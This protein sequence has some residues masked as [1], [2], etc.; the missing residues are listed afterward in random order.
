MIIESLFQVMLDWFW[1]S[2]S[3]PFL[4]RRSCGYT[5]YTSSGARNGRIHQVESPNMGPK[6][7]AIDLPL[8]LETEPPVGLIYSAAK[9]SWR[10]QCGFQ[11]KEVNLLA[12]WANHG[13]PNSNWWWCVLLMKLGYSKIVLLGY[14]GIYTPCLDKPLTSLEKWWRK[15]GVF[16]T[17]IGIGHWMFEYPKRVSEFQWM[18]WKWPKPC[19][20]GFCKGLSI[21]PVL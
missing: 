4:S 17:Q 3:S 16:T 2:M 10:C 21:L 5:W 9:E 20:I 15:A 6:I 12:H 11:R 1:K 13:K 8:N 19:L 14:T 18:A 7:P